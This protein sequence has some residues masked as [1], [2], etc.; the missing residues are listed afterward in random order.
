MSIYSYVPFF[1]YLY[2]FLLKI[3]ITIV[4][5]VSSV[6]HLQHESSQ[7]SSS[8]APIISSIIV[9]GVARFR[10]LLSP[11]SLISGVAHLWRPH[12][13]RNY[14]RYNDLYFVS[15]SCVLQVNTDLASSNNQASDTFASHI[16]QD[17][18]PSHVLS[19]PERLHF[20]RVFFMKVFLQ[21]L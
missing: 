9:S 1:I 16:V 19:L 18:Y 13:C 3:E 10:R 8:P 12:L 7:P 21:F 14:L 15:L 2:F 11:V 5:L 6:D 20:C 17:S 4:L